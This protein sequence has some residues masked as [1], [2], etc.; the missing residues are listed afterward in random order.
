MF[1]AKQPMNGFFHSSL[2]L[3][4]F[5]F[6]LFM[7]I[8]DANHKGVTGLHLLMTQLIR[9]VIRTI[10]RLLRPLAPRTT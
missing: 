4:Q 7:C 5:R 2:Q 10:S 6:T 9:S 8:L 1:E 3:P